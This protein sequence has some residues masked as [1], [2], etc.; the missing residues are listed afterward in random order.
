MMPIFVPGG[1]QYKATIGVGGAGGAANSYGGRGGTTT[2]TLKIDGV[3][4]TIAAR[5]GYEGRP[6]GTFAGGEA[7]MTDPIGPI[8][9]LAPI[10]RS[11]GYSTGRIVVLTQGGYGGDGGSRYGSSVNGEDGG[12]GTAFLSY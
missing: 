10:P 5:G 8:S 7:V 12:N 1:S 11:D 9:L 6:G 4:Y 2:L 3:T